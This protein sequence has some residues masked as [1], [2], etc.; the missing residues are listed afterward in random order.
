[1]YVAKKDRQILATMIIAYAPK[2]RYTDSTLVMNKKLIFISLASVIVIAGSMVGILLIVKSRTSAPVVQTEPEI[3]LSSDGSRDYGACTFVSKSFIKSTIGEPAAKL[4]GPDTVGL[5]QLANGDQVQ[6]C[7]Y[8]FI[9]GGTAANQFNVAD[10]FSIE[11]FIH[12]D[13]TSKQAYIELQGTTA[14]SVSGI[15]DKATYTSQTFTDGHISYSLLVYTGL[16]HYTF[17][18]NQPVDLKKFTKDSAKQI[19]TTIAKSATY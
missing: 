9:E 15:G 5:A 3:K 11:V 1:M 10:G 6:V 13:E 4:Q 17:V 7:A 8:S 18:I 12:K 19:L 14:E 16:R 2:K